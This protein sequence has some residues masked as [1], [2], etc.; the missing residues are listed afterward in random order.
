MVEEIAE[1]QPNGSPRVVAF[2]TLGAAMA[3]VE[4]NAIRLAERLDPARWRVVL[5]CPQ[6]GDLPNAFRRAGL[7]VRIVRRPRLFSSSIPLG[8]K[9]R[10]PNPFACLWDCGAILVAARTLANV[11]AEMRPDLVVTKG[12]FSHF[13]GGLAAR[14]A[15]VP[16]LWHAED[17][18]SERWGGVFRHAFGLAARWI[19]TAVAVIGE[20]I[21][22]QLP[23]GVQK[24]V[25][26]IHNAADTHAFRPGVDGSAVRAGLGIPPDALIVGHVARLTPWKG[27]HH[28]L[29]AFG[30]IAGQVPRARLLLV[31]SPVFDTDTY[32]RS[33]RSRAAALGL[34]DRV[35]FAGYRKDVPQV[36]AAMDVLAYPSVEKDNCPLS[37]LEG[38]ATGL[39]VVAFD[40]PGVR[41]VLPG[42]ED[43]VL[44]PVERADL[45]AD[46]LLRLLTD[47]DFRHRLARGARRRIETAFSLQRQ[48]QEFEE[49]FHDTIEKGGGWRVAGRGRRQPAFFSRHAPAAT[50]HPTRSLL[51]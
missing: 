17:F 29:E 46:A 48:V 3:G 51:S 1:T 42:T 33:L 6:E 25:R 15:G 5:L 44:V 50:R 30:R 38:M 4:Y 22:Q 13:Y 2:V 16:C 34:A 20:P 24:K 49:A 11:L 41:F 31:G 45:L 28:L 21:A 27:Q 9:W 47:D 8:R 12:L 26:V 18:I 14:Q 35:H 36:L 19:P 23:A 32:E 37:L 10:I 40:I 7:G 43:G 39:P